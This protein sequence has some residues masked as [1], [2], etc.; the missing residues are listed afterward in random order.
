MQDGAYWSDKAGRPEIGQIA[1]MIMGWRSLKKLLSRTI[2][3][4]RT[5]GTNGKESD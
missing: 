3:P 5:F 4:I 1:R 2:A